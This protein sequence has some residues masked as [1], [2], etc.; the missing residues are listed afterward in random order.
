MISFQACGHRSVLL[1]SFLILL[2][3]TSMLLLSGVCYSHT[4]TYWSEIYVQSL[5]ICVQIIFMVLSFENVLFFNSFWR[6]FLTAI[7]LKLKVWYGESS[8]TH[9]SGSLSG[10][11]RAWWRADHLNRVCWRRKTSKTCR[12]VALEDWILT[13]LLYQI[14]DQWKT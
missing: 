12:I 9:L 14:T 7:A 8:S 1:C 11:C 13:P 4:A 2:K 6:G 5:L 3:N 10:L